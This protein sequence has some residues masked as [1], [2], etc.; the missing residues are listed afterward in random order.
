MS[1]VLNI[2]MSS[3]SE[4]SVLFKALSGLH[5][6]YT[7][8][9]KQA[10]KLRSTAQN[11]LYWGCYVAALRNHLLKQGDVISDDLIHDI[12]K[13]KFLPARPII[14]HAT[15]E[16]IGMVGGSTTD[17]STVEFN[18]YLDRIQAYLAETFGIEL[19]GIGEFAPEEH[20]SQR[21]TVPRIERPALPAGVRYAG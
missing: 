20:Q 14:S 7:I 11:R 1:I 18:E 19:P 17:L 4:K 15:G 12:Y 21:V 13:N 16:L 3:P 8:D 6:M 9:I 5:G 2:Q 10:R